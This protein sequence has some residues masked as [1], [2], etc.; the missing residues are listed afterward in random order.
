MKKQRIICDQLAA[1]GWRECSNQFKTYS[2]C[3]YKRFDTPTRC[4]G[5]D[6]K[7]GMQIEI[8]VSEYDTRTSIELELC[9]GLK[10]ETWLK[11]RKYCLPK[12]L[13]EVL[14]LIPRMLAVWEAANKEDAKNA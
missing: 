6:D 11:L 7:P 1:A 14:K 4:S 9:A 2:R 13:N 8:G 3:F 10:D 12:D 5:N